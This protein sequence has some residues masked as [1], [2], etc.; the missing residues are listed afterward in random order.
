MSRN[1]KSQKYAKKNKSEFTRI[2][3]KKIRNTHLQTDS[4]STII[5]VQKTT[6]L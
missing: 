3:G 1:K 5:L 6:K 4:S 2:N